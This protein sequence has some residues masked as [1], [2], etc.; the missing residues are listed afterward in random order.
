MP[1]IQLTQSAYEQILIHMLQ[2]G[3]KSLRKSEEAMGLIYGIRAGEN[4]EIRKTIP[5]K[6][7][8]TCEKPFTETDFIAFNEIDQKVLPD[9]LECFGYYST[10]PKTG[11]YLSQNEIKN[12]LYFVNEKKNPYAIA[13]I[14][15]HNQLE[16][17]DNPGLK[18]FRL[19]DASKGTASDF[20]ILS[21]K[22]ESPKG[23]SLFKTTKMLIEQGQKHQPYVEEQGSQLK[24]DDSLWDSMGDTETPEEKMKK[25]L[26]PTISALQQDIPNVEQS[27]IASALQTYNSFLED[28]TQFAAKTLNDPGNDAVNMRLAIEDGLR[29]IIKWFKATLITQNGRVFEDYQRTIQTIQEG[30]Q[31]AEKALKLVL[32]QLLNEYSNNK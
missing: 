29:N 6:H 9:G 28:L 32:I 12:L 16:E 31:E 21:L 23:L 18:V 30:Q 13:V 10:H 20:E 22:I 14:G 1:T 25:K 27:F 11:F 19:K 7:G 4:I 26:Q 17:K 2:Y 3:N 8:S 15:D 5:V 24:A